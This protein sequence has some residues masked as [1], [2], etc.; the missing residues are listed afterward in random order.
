MNGNGRLW[1]AVIAFLLGC[2]GSGLTTQIIWG[3]RLARIEALVERQTHD[4]DLHISNPV[5]HHVP[6]K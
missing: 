4:L 2:V 5:A 6:F 1:T 3:Q